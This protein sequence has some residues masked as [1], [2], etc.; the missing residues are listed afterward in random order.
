[1]PVT[2]TLMAV[3]SWSVNLAPDT[4]RT[5]VDVLSSGYFGHV[6]IATGRHDPRVEGDS[7]LTS[8]RYVGVLTGG[9]FN[10]RISGNGPQLSGDGMETWLATPNG[11]GAVYETP[12]S[13][14][15]ATFASVVNALLPSSVHAGTI[16][17]IGSQTYT[18]A[19]VWT[20]PRKALTT[21]C[22]LMSSGPAANQ[23]VEWRV[24]GNATLDAGHVSDLYVT[25]PSTAIVSRAAGVDMTVRALPGVAQLIEDVTDFT[26]RVV[27]LASGSGTSTAVGV[28]NIGDVGGTNPY[29][30]LYGNTVK[31][32]RMV[33]ASSVSSYNATAAAQTAILPYILP[34][35]QVKLTSQEYDITGELSVGDY[36]YVYDPDAGIVDA[37]NEIIFRGQRINPALLRVIELDWPIVEGMTVAYRAGDGTWYDLTDYVIW[38][39]GDTTVVVGGYNRALVSSAEPVGG[40][41]IPDTTIPGVPAFG[42]FSTTVY[43]GAS[44]GKTKAQIQVTWATPTN[45]DGT[46]IT[47][48]DHYEVQYRPDLGIYAQNPSYNQLQTAGY[49]Y[50][51]LAAQGGTYKGLIPQQVSDWKVTF[52]AWGVNNLLVQELTPG[53]NYDFQIRAVDTATP[54]NR[55]A[56]SATSTVQA[57][58][59]TIPPPTPDA[60]SVAA[61]M[62]SV[63]VTWD[64]GT[65]DGGSFTQAVDLHH[66]EVH[67][68]YDPLF[69]PTGSTKLG[70]VIANVGNIT[71]RIP[72]VASF[73]IPPGQPPAQSMYI[74]IIAVDVTGNKSNPSAAA[75]ATAVLWSNAYISDLSVSKLT[76]GTITASIILGGTIATGSSGQRCVM[77]L[78]G[79][80]SYDANGNLLFDVNN[81]SSQITLGAIGGVGK[82]VIDTSPGDLYP[83]V[84]F[85]DGTNTNYGF[86]LAANLNGASAAMAMSSSDYTSGGKGYASRVILD[87]YGASLNVIDSSNQN[88]NGG[89]WTVNAG[90]INGAVQAEGV[91]TGPAV[92]M[93]STG[94]QVAMQTAGSGDGGEIQLSES[95][96]MLGLFPAGATHGGQL[97]FNKNASAGDSSWEVDGYRTNNG[98]GAPFAQE[99]MFGGEIGALSGSGVSWGYGSTMFS[100]PTAVAV[101]RDVNTT[102][103]PAWMM[104]SN[105]A[106]GFGLAAA[107]SFTNLYSVMFWAFRVR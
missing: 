94:F 43:Q 75:G 95:Q 97:L 31:M 72:V 90:G 8:A 45:T 83:Q 34:R 60:P 7:L 61:N 58:V 99:G 54:P 33:S 29:V 16:H 14:T 79:F 98:V 84:R 40:R 21:L 106:T 47:D 1:M 103:I 39:S 82:V 81:Y 102:T 50:N 71:G 107:A 27:V 62:A 36:T 20:D 22:S 10:S 73:G 13:F 91:T 32:T 42:Q 87:G 64:C 86:I 65:S 69:T 101:A 4:P 38:E 68:S 9:T 24:N 53:V 67:G 57:A 104:T 74:K 77:D 12:L 80:H 3:G 25:S 78:T 76:A 100:T 37:T 55:S 35:D 41:P 66:I 48:G 59:D 89:I 23:T 96:A 26:D 105:S 11:V 44:D 2:K 28:A 88:V 63:Q 93:S 49:T 92:A 51:G 18:G 17:S 19:F 52:V 70:N 30:D 15:A 6:A 5:L 46:T 85:Y 56:W